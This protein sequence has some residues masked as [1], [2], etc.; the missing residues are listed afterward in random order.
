[1]IKKEYTF[2]DLFAGLGGFH[3]ALQELGCK[4]VFASELKEDLRKLYALNF[5]ETPIYGDITKIHPEQIPS[6]DII[7]GGFPC[8]PFSIMGFRK[9]FN[10]PRGNLFF[11][12]AR[13]A[14]AKLPK[15]IKQTVITKT[16]CS[17]SY[18]MTKRSC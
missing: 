15:V 9:G 14:E 8:Q 1:M 3:L 5:P 17:A 2:I 16:P 18:L 7:C 4:C 6:H 12:I 11:E 13:I 10:D